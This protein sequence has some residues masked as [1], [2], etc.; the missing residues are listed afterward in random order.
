MATVVAVAIARSH[1]GEILQGAIRCADGIH[2][3]LL[4]LPAPTLFTRAELLATPKHELAVDPPWATK[5]LAAARLF[6]RRFGLQPP[7]ATIRLTTNIPVGKGCGSSTT[8]ILATLRALMTYYRL[9]IIEEDLAGLIVEAEEASDGSILSHP[10]IFRH[11]EGLVHQYLPGLF[12]NI[13]VIVIDAQPGVT[14][15]TVSLQ[16]ARY[17]EDELEGFAVLIARVNRA[18]RMGDPSD[19]GA[20]ATASARISQRQ[21]SMAKPHLEQMI[22]LVENQGGYGLSVS[23]SGTICSA[24]LPATCT[25]ESRNRILTVANELGM[26]TVTEFELGRVAWEVAA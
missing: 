26:Q 19:L 7:E 15:P 10:A 24:L 21:P 8:D 23:H 9:P 14:V 25:A 16:R 12:P 2:R 22:S 4:S 1:A 20:V 13:H 3:L 11:R 18:F 5:A 6:L 17:S